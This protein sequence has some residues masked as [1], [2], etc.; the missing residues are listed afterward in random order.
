MLGNTLMFCKR[1]YWNIRYINQRIALKTGEKKSG[2][3]CLFFCQKFTLSAIT[4]AKPTEQCATSF[5][6]I[7]M[8]K[9]PFLK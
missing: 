7:M 8:E 6:N 1:K 5:S 4:L 3:Q 2:A 9:Q